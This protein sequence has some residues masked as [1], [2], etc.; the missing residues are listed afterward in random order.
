M[1][2][3]APAQRSFWFRS[4]FDHPNQPTTVLPSL[5]LKIALI[6]TGT[7]GD[8]QPYAA[9]S[10]ELVRGGAVVTLI[11]NGNFS[12]LCAMPGCAFVPL[13]GDVEGFMGSVEMRRCLDRGDF[14]QIH[15]LAMAETG[16]HIV[17]WLRICAASTEGHDLIV[18]GLGGAFLAL[19]IS[20]VS[21]TPVAL[22]SLVPFAATSS[23]P[24]PL[25]PGVLFHSIPF[26]RRA[27]HRLGRRMFWLTMRETVNRARVE[28]LGLAPRGRSDPLACIDRG[29]LPV[30]FGFSSHL[31]PR[32]RDWGAHIRVTG[33]WFLDAPEHWRAPTVLES[34]LADGDPPV[35]IGFGSMTSERSS[36]LMDAI[37]CAVEQTGTRVIFLAGW[38]EAEAQAR[39]P[40][41]RILGLKSAPHDWLYPRCAAVIHHG[42]AGT[43]AAVLRSGKPSLIAPVFADQPFWGNTVYEAGVGL[44]PVAR[45]RL[46]VN[47]LAHAFRALTSQTEL[48]NRARSLGERIRAEDGAGQ[49]A[50]LLCDQAG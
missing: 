31:I 37:G 9:L 32:P 14:L 48:L 15:R 25:M 47:T 1:W 42:G 6:T 23:F 8:V 29:P 43:T 36:H 3:P 39:R 40:N 50:R 20:E 38:S 34:F 13:P 19:A 35:C 7:R 46:D 44:R 33:Y 21:G 22:A 26:L 12:E 4:P 27:S 11:T 30:L 45:S 17:D 2:A 41:P 10:R 49:A 28:A 24:S 18:A 5:N 16:R